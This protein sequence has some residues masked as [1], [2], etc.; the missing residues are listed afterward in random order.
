MTL[1]FDDATFAFTEV[2]C[3][4]DGRFVPTDRFL[5]RL[6]AEYMDRDLGKEAEKMVDWLR[7][8]RKRRLT[9]AFIYNWLDKA[10]SIRRAAPVGNGG[11]Y[12]AYGHSHTTKADVVACMTKL[13]GQVI[14]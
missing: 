4:Y 9:V 7:R 6:L 3:H 5:H 8:Q 13:H 2:L 11:Y 14:L 1:P 10:T 12:C